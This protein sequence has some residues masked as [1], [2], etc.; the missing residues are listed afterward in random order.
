MSI[1]LA[2]NGNKRSSARNIYRNPGMT[3]NQ[4]DMHIDRSVVRAGLV[5]Q[6]SVWPRTSIGEFALEVAASRVNAGLV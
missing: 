4:G 5:A 1:S 6:M 3:E 2:T